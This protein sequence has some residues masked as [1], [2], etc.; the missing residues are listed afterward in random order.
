MVTPL[1]PQLTEKTYAL[2]KDANTYVFKVEP[3]LNKLQIKQ[4]IQDEY[5]VEVIGL[6]TLIAKGK[7]IGGRFGRPAGRRK[8][9]KK[10]YITLKEGDVI[11]VFTN[12]SEEDGQEPAKQGK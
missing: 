6:R 8:T 7:R 10:A 2:A 4:Q 12:F 5:D 9:V 3:S 11:P 1:I